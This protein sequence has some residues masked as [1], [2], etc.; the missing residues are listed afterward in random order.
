MRN[1]GPITV[2]KLHPLFGAEICGID[3]TQ[4]L[5]PREFGPIRAAFE[6]HSVLLFRDQPM[7]DEKQIRFSEY[8]GPLE[9]TLSANPAAGT[10]FARQSNLDIMTGEPIPPDDMRMIYQ[11]ANYFWHSDSSFKRI[12]SLCSVLTARICPAEGGNTEFLSMRAAWNALPPALQATIEPLI[13]EHA[14]EYSRN[15][16]QKGILS[17]KSLAELPAVKQRLFQDNPINGRRALYIGAH[18]GFIIGWPRETG[19]ALLHELTQRADQPEFRLSQAWREGDVVVWDNRAV[20]HRATYYDA[21]KYKRLMQRTTISG[22]APT[23]MQ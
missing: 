7:D 6:E 12:P 11:K 19:E 15:R 8:F 2:R 9:T 16:V 21:V 4:P 20:L 5:S 10:K 1:T 23:V 18:A 17:A 13:A 14:L 3:I 22:D